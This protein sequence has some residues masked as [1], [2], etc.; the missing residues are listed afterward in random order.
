[1]YICICIK[2]ICYMYIKIYMYTHTILYIY[3][4]YKG[5]SYLG[6]KQ[7][8][9]FENRKLYVFKHEPC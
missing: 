4:I 5:K 7:Q 6:L 3:T 2:Y 9:K 1:M 8:C